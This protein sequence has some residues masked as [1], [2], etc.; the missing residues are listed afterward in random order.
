MSL[1]AGGAGGTGDAGGAGGGGAG[2]AGGAG[3]G[4]M[5]FTNF[6]RIDIGSP[7]LIVGL[8]SRPE[9][10]GTRGV[11]RVRK[12]D[13]WGVELAGDKS[14]ISLHPK[15]L[16]GAELLQT[17]TS[18]NGGAEAIKSGD[19]RTL[20][21]LG[22]DL[23]NQGNYDAAMGCFQRALSLCIS[24]LG[25]NH[26]HV[27][28]IYRYMASVFAN[29]GN[30]Q[31]SMEYSLKALPI[32]LRACGPEH[33][34]TGSIY[35]NIGSSLHM[36][37]KFEEAMKYY[38]KALPIFTKSFGR[39]HPTTV[40]LLNLMS[41]TRDTK[42]AAAI[43]AT[44]DQAT[45]VE[46]IK[47]GDGRT[48]YQVGVDLA[49]QDIK[50]VAAIKA[51]VD[52]ATHVETIKSDDLRTLYQV[53]MDLAEQGKYDAALEHFQRALPLC[54]SE[55][56]PNHHN[57]G[58][59]YVNMA[60][61]FSS[62]SKHQKSMECYLKALP[63][64]L[65]EFGPEHEQTGR[66]YASI[67]SALCMQSKFEE[68]MKYYKKALPIYTKSLGQEHPATEN[69][70]ELMSAATEGIKKAAAITAT[71]DQVQQ[72]EAIKSEDWR[73]LYKLGLALA[74][75]DKVKEALEHFQ[76]A[77]PLCIS[78][79]GQNHGNV[80]NI[81][82]SMAAM[83]SSQG[84]HQKSMEYFIKALPITLREFGPEHE[85]IGRIYASIG[86]ALYAQH[87][88]EE[89][90]KYAK[91]A[92]PIFTKS[93]GREHPHTVG[94]LK[95][96]SAA[97]ED[98]KKAA[99]I[100]AKVDQAQQ[101]EAI[102]SEDWRTLN[103][104]GLVLTKQGNH[105]AALEHS[106]RALPL[107]ISEHGPNHPNVGGIYV[108][109]AAMFSSQGK[110][111]KSMEYFIK[112]LP[113][114]LRAYGPEHEQTGSI[115]ANIGTALDEQSKFEEAIKYYK[116]ALPIFTKSLGREHPHTVG[117]LKHVSAATEDIKKAA[118]VKATVEQALQAGTI[119]SGDC[120]TLYHCG[121][122]LVKQGN[123]DAAM[124][125]FQRALP[126]MLHACGPEHEDT[127]AIYASI[128]SVLYMQ[129]K[130]EEA[131]KYYK[132]A[133]PIYTK[134]FGREHAATEGILTCISV[135]TEGIKKAATIKATVDQA[136][137]AG[138]ATP[139]VKLGKEM[140]GKS[141]A[142]TAAGCGGPVKRDGG[143]T[144]TLSITML[145]CS[146][147]T[148]EKPL[149]QFSKAQQKK[150]KKKG[151]RKCADCIAEAE[152]A[153][154]EAKS[155]AEA[156]KVLK[157]ERAALAAAAA[158]T[159]AAVAEQETAKK[160]AAE[161]AL[162]EAEA[163]AL[164][165][166]TEVA[167]KKRAAE[168][169]RKETEAAAQRQLKEEEAAKKRA[170]EKVRKEAKATA[171]RQA[172][173]AKEAAAKEIRAKQQRIKD[174][175][176]AK[177][178]ESDARKAEEDVLKRLE[179]ERKAEQEAKCT[180]PSF[181]AEAMLQLF[182]AF[183][184]V[185][186][187]VTIY[188]VN[189]SNYSAQGIAEMD[190]GNALGD[191]YFRTRS[192]L[193]PIEC[194]EDPRS[195]DCYNPE[196]T[197]EDLTVTKVQDCRYW[198]CIRVVQGMGSPNQACNGQVGV[199]SVAE[200]FGNEKVHDG[201]P[202]WQYWKRNLAWKTGGTWYSTPAAG[203]GKYWKVLQTIK[204]VNKTCADNILWT[205]IRTK[206][207]DCFNGC[208]QPTNTTTDCNIECFYATL[209]GPG[210]DFELGNLRGV[211]VAGWLNYCGGCLLDT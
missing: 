106:R 62:Q 47:S 59:I 56:G 133:L 23:A 178:A 79:L 120:T 127:G 6:T 27:G 76:R 163:A 40:G 99:A 28:G 7:V 83:F 90:M 73:T 185:A 81:Y 97:T 4:R 13:R 5:N 208:A 15:N 168:K 125:C 46:T 144:D 191:F 174:E 128:G 135:A 119:E 109:M 184:A 26:E 108:S 160:R 75:Q 195:H 139:K 134:S 114:T 41:A 50:K 91:K 31:K 34:D 14:I 44:V 165:Q 88:F 197:S 170:A 204:Q 118:A 201:A 17:I 188:H 93:F 199:E 124:G 196:V 182:T 126:I 157:V 166:V 145:L 115:Y 180:T 102:K 130:F 86:S 202:A 103:D 183:L 131:M 193:S 105:D 179:A 169:V 78:K 111:Q 65:R 71:V 72:A 200:H 140:D 20:Y 154:R 61:M 143:V 3:V 43:K 96:V 52:Q 175:E 8:K 153:T 187:V 141:S 36:Q 87:K 60:A 98:I 177:Q 80:G 209:I 42:K 38:K 68:A 9:L 207:P 22:F 107:C 205:A 113:I 29:Q 74:E 84:K 203:E 101:A 210:K 137:Q 32:M 173:E 164:R 69:L 142:P 172:E 16:E 146:V 104:L 53:G 132:K 123:H 12:S 35:A 70:L 116:K 149:D 67:G 49:K 156:A 37:H 171:Q 63:I 112:A 150:K 92:L 186:D 24:E 18:Y 100:K 138:D 10:N 167:A 192:V 2:D 189:P 48:L 94:L 122:V 211:D 176:A 121:F 85:Q 161:K 136:R 30:G 58:N 25:P 110:Q 54:I 64:T 190:T 19:W 194:R 206:N 21:K 89:A 181:F 158:A 117:L 55:H 66:I 33:A 162:K 159:A 155:A 11:V 151:T 152:V 129:S 39:E 57:V 45:H 82:V 95:H 51:T 147:C 198:E 1:V 77:I 148:T